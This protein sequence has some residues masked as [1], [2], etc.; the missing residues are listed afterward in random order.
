MKERRIIP[1]IDAVYITRVG[2]DD[3]YFALTQEV[4]GGALGQKILFRMGSDTLQDLADALSEIAQD[5]YDW[6]DDAD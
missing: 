3:G 1:Q 2:C 6:G 4:N 5:R